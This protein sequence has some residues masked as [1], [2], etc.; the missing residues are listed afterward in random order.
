MLRG[1]IILGALAGA[2]WYAYRKVMGSGTGL[3]PADG[4]I[5]TG[6]RSAAGGIAERVRQSVSQAATTT[7]NKVRGA[8]ADGG[9]QAPA[10]HAPPATEADGTLPEVRAAAMAAMPAMQ[11]PAPFPDA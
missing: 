11:Q 5:G 2:G 8:A 10:D 9:Q 6:D 1:V 4:P 7:V 3:V